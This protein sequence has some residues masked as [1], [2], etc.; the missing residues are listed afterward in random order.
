MATDLR[1]S[2]LKKPV[3]VAE[4]LFR[5]LHE[6]GVRGVHGIP[7]DY[8]LVSHLSPLPLPSTPI[9]AGSARLHLQAWPVLGWKLQRVERWYVSRL[10]VGD[11]RLIP[12]ATLRMDMQELRAFQRW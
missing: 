5:R 8:N 3:D 1:T 7:G 10:P 11:S 12:K 4:Y 2:E 6:V 9:T